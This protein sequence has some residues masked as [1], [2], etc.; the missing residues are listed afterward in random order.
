MHALPHTPDLQIAASAQAIKWAD[1][2]H[3][4]LHQ[5]FQRGAPALFLRALQ[6]DTHLIVFNLVD[7]VREL[8]NDLPQ[9][10]ARDVDGCVFWTLRLAFKNAQEAA[11]KI[12]Q[13]ARQHTQPGAL[14]IFE[15]LEQAA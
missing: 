10:P 14:P 11:Q 9:M 5:V 2:S 12:T 15:E 1:G 7:V 4:G 8:R 6:S 13:H 3:I